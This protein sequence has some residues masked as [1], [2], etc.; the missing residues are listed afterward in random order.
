[1]SRPHTAAAAAA[2]LLALA[3]LG[4]APRLDPLEVSERFWSAVA[5]GD[6]AAARAHVAPRTAPE[7]GLGGELL[8]I[9]DARLGRA[10]IEGDRARVE[11]TVTLDADRPLD[12]PLETVLLRERE[13]WRVDYAATVEGLRESDG[14]ARVLRGF[15]DAFD[16]LGA[17]LG[18]E[19]ERS[20]SEIERA[21]PEL[22]RELER[23]EREIRARVPELERRLEELRRALEEALEP[24]L[25]P[26]PADAPREV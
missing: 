11:T 14:L 20:V 3:V 26:P 25:E 7:A 18:R 19:V 2:A 15:R 5:A 21:L 6:A 17:T 4:C 8:P 24:A 13:R 10:V 9:S 23:A 16:E 12:V 22:K 1:M